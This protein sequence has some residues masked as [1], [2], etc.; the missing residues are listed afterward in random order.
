M[1]SPTGTECALDRPCCVFAREGKWQPGAHLVRWMA[2]IT[3]EPKKTGDSEALSPPRASRS[4]AVPASRRHDWIVLVCLGLTVLACY[5]TTLIG[6]MERWWNDPQYSHGFLVPF[7]VGYL[8]WFRLPQLAGATPA[9]TAWG[10]A[11]LVAALALRFVSALLAIE[12]LDAYSLLPMMAGLTLL[13]GGWRYLC[14]SWPAIAFLAFMMPLPFQMEIALAQPLRRLATTVTTYVLQTIGY[15][16]IAEGNVIHIE[17]LR[18]GVVDACS[19]LGMMVTFF[20]LATAMALV[21]QATPVEKSLIIVSAI[22]IALLA[23]V[24]RITATAVAHHTLGSQ[25]A[26]LVM[27][28]LAGWLMMPLA[29]GVLWFELWFFRRLFIVESQPQ[30]LPLGVPGMGASGMTE[31]RM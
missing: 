29:L 16:A 30:V 11:F 25:A 28:D 31:Q 8:L 17:Q 5:W 22:P 15:P 26:R 18:L 23:N 20:T 12:A 13:L 6:L 4:A 7:F 19:G 10:M 21:V 3:L 9:P 1:P 2:L 27:H 24:T 14:W